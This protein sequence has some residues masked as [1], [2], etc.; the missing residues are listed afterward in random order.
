[1]TPAARSTEAL[2]VASFGMRFSVTMS[3]FSSMTAK[4]LRKK[5]SKTQRA[6]QNWEGA[7][8]PVVRQPRAPDGPG[9]MHRLTGTA[10]HGIYVNFFD[11][12]RI[13]GCSVILLKVRM[14]WCDGFRMRN[15]KRV[16]QN[17]NQLLDVRVGGEHAERD[18]HNSRRLTIDHIHAIPARMPLLQVTA[19]VAIGETQVPLGSSYIAQCPGSD[20]NI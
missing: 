7:L 17:L 14:R 5:V 18:P 4:H 2:T 20:L 9:T 8:A 12:K 3:P 13:L 15:K 19:E 11:D 10:L 6:T 16:S 1:M